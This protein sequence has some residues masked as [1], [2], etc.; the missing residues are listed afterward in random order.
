MRRSGRTFTV[1]TYHRVGDAGSGPPG[2][3]S[4]TPEQFERQMRLARARPAGPSRSTRCC[5][6]ARRRRPL[7]RGAVLVTF[8]DAY[9]DFRDEAW[10]V[11]R[12]HGVPV[13]LFVP[14]AFP[15]S[16]RRFWWDRLF[17]ALRAA[18]ARM[19][20]TPVGPLSLDVAATSSVAAYRRLREHVKSL[21]H[22][23]A[24]ALV[25]RLVAELGP[26]P[27]GLPGV[28]G[29]DALRD[30]AAEGVALAAHSRT[31]PLLNRLA[32]RAPGGRDRRLDGRPARAHGRRHARPSRTRAAACRPTRP[33]VVAEAGAVVA[34]TTEVG[35]NDARRRRLAAPAA[36]QRRAAHAA[37]SA[38]CGRASRWPPRRRGAGAPP[39]P[40]RARPAARRTSPT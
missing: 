34:F 15:D 9:E 14:T 3:V 4:C 13:T 30:L 27:A 10:P 39:T 28:L 35:G 5:A 33:R 32:G 17:A 37:R 7:P 29:W 38:S 25:D 16:G 23:E 12:R 19:L 18:P 31:H 40:A 20:D 1:L 24:M 8:D 22:D 2:I 36:H 6:R 21:P 26:E 11:L